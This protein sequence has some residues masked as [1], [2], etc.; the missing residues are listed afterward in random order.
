M[1]L[2]VWEMKGSRYLD[3]LEVPRLEWRWKGIGE[4]DV[5][6]SVPDVPYLVL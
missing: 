4:R 3:S 2:I 1:V 6:D 5:V